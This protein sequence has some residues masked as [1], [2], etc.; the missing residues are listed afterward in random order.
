MMPAALPLIF[1]ILLLGVFGC[2]AQGYSAETAAAHMTS[3]ADVQVALFASEP[4][5]V[6]PVCIEFDDRGRLWVMQYIQYPNPSG[7]KRASVDR[8]SRTIYDRVPEPPPKGPK[9]SDRITILE[10]LDARGR[11]HK[12]H[13]FVAG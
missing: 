11:A 8:W 6:Q 12:E 3:P 4:M 9:G 7:L 5:I 10:D 1:L 13:V 2:G